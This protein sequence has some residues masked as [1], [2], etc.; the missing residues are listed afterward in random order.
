MPGNFLITSLTILLFPFNVSENKSKLVHL[1]SSSLLY[2]SYWTQGPVGILSPGSPDVL[3]VQ[4]S[5]MY[6]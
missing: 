2:K 4:A 3:Q 1:F 6:S 5:Q